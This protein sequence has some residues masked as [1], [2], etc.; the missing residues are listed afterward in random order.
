MNRMSTK[1][2]TKTCEN[3]TF[4]ALCLPTGLNK[5]ELE[6]LEKIIQKRREI[7]RHEHIFHTGDPF[8]QLYAIRAGSF[9]S[10]IIN[11]E[12]KEQIRGFNLPAE[13]LGIDGVYTRK[14][15]ISV[16]ALEDGLVCELPFNQLL[17]LAGQIPALQQQLFHL[18]SQNYTIHLP[19]SFNSPA[20]VRFAAFLLNMS[21]R[22]EERGFASQ[23]FTLPMSREDIGNYLGLATE[24]ISRLFNRFEEKKVLTV[25]HRNV[26]LNDLR[27]LQVIACE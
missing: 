20:E 6:Q 27:S 21:R 5:E 23:N 2:P 11:S 17:M 1:I 14:H 9:K 15:S 18:M 19:F 4:S 12:G 24:T 13:L 16:V 8:Q 10:Y 22:L 26:Y 25:K 3:C 7:K